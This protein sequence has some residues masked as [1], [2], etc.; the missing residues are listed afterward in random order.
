MSEAEIRQEYS[1]LDR[2][3]KN[4]QAFGELYEKYFDRIF[5]F[6]YRQTDDEELTADLCSQTF[7]IALKNVDRYQFRGVPFSA[8]LYKIASNEVNKHY[9]KQ[10][11][12]KVFSIEEVRI[13]E[14][15]EQANEEYDEEIIHRLMNFLKELPTEML[16]VLELRF[17]ED[18]DFK[19]IAF[20]LEIT[21]SGA[22]MRTYRAL[23]RLRKSFNLRIKYD[24]KE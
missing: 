18:K 7:L 24:G 16:Q 4:P 5:N 9:R 13:R 12:T 21:E 19:E 11:H 3:K 14:L 1:I 15:I 2:S 22:K 10:K 8:W 23:D 6:I 20:I 17:F